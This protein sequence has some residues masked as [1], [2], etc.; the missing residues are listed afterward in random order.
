MVQL[1]YGVAAVNSRVPPFSIRMAVQGA[2]EELRLA[3]VTLLLG[4]PVAPLALISFAPVLMVKALA[5]EVPTEMNAPLPAET[6][7]D[8][9]IILEPLMPVTKVPIAVAS[10]ANSKLFPVPLEFHS[11]VLVIFLDAPTNFTSP[12]APA[13]VVIIELRPVPPILVPVYGV[14]PPSV[15][16]VMGVA[17]AVNALILSFTI[18]LN[19]EDM[20]M[21]LALLNRFNPLQKAS[22]ELT[23]TKWPA[24]M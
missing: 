18:T 21:A 1:T 5:A 16:S 4:D 9:T 23:V 14:A 22:A 2:P 3:I 10:S 13:P 24:W 15:A 20:V 19:V 12:V 7:P 8:E 6:V 11:L 17:G